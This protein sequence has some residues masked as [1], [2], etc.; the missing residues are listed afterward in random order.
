MTRNTTENLLPVGESCRSDR[1]GRHCLTR[2]ITATC[3]VRH[4]CCKNQWL[5]SLP[6]RARRSRM[7]QWRPHNSRQIRCGKF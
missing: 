4:R 3:I 1:Y 7:A 2:Q 6:R 5:R